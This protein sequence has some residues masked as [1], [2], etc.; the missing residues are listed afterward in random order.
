[1]NLQLNVNPGVIKDIII[2]N[3]AA[4]QSAEVKIIVNADGCSYDNTDIG[5]GYRTFIDNLP[6]E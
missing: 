6:G 2:P 1:M 5:T 3:A 4:S